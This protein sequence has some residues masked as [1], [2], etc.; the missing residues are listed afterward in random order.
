MKIW[1]MLLL[2]LYFHLIEL[3]LY[4]F[5]AQIMILLLFPTM[6]VLASIF[7][8]TSISICL[9][10]IS[11]MPEPALSFSIVFVDVR[12]PSIILPVV[13]IFTFIAWMIFILDCERTPYS[14]EME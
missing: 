1:A 8:F 14:F 3:T 2:T 5:V 9:S 7:K 10:F 12:L 6:A 11:S 4:C 13:S